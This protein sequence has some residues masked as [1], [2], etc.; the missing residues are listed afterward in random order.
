MPVH[1]GRI[2]IN[3]LYGREAPK[4]VANFKA[5]CTGERGLDK[6]SKKPLHYKVHAVL[7]YGSHV[8]V[9][10]VSSSTMASPALKC[11]ARAKVSAL[12][13]VRGSTHD[14][15]LIIAKHMYDVHA[16]KLLPQDCEGLCVPG[17]RCH[18]RCAPSHR[19]LCAPDT[20]DKLSA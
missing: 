2:A 10:C 12:F 20:V 19:G 3:L 4:A 1:A 17:R 11:C 9:M 13:F 14:G 16:G 7:M 18:Q 5:L 15:M 6:A 8:L